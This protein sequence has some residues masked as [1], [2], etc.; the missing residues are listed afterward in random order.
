MSQA[1]HPI[2]NVE[3]VEEQ[4]AGP[5][6]WGGFMEGEEYMA[7]EPEGPRIFDLIEVRSG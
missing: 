2:A 7:G 1:V 3:E 6:V 5:G 4:S